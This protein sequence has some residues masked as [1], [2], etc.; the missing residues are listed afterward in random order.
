[1]RPTRPLR[2]VLDTNIVLDLL[3]FRDPGVTCLAQA[4]DAGFAVGFTNEACLD[5]LQHVLSQPQ[6]GLDVVAQ[7]RN[8]VHYRRLAVPV[9]DGPESAEPPLPLCAD[10]DDQ[11]FL[12][13]ARNA[14]ADCL[15]TKDKALLKLRRAKVGL[16]GFRIVTPADLERVLTGE[17]VRW[18]N[19]AE[20]GVSS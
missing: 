5:E 12:E 4:L 16:N 13:L 8:L 15:V 18:P 1:M 14:R 19:A 11:K 20:R 17:T 10:P 2:L 9:T 7:E 6:W 3:L